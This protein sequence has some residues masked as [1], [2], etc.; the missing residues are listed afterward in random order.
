MEVKLTTDWILLLCD[1]VYTSNGKG[2]IVL[3]D[4]GFQ[5]HLAEFALKTLNVEYECE[6]LYDESDED[7]KNPSYYFTI[8]NIDDIKESSPELY[9]KFQEHIQYKI[10]QQ[11]EDL[12]KRTIVLN[13][14]DTPKTQTQILKRLDIEFYKKQED[15]DALK[16]W[17]KARTDS[18]IGDLLREGLIKKKGNKYSLT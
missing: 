13:F 6:E 11:K 10:N 1:E 15:Y 5:Y 12:I 14:L 7:F 9:L 16:R 17:I 8:E 2:C 3:Y 18:L 4:Y